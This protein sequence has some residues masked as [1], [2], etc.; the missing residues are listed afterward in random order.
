MCLITFNWNP[1]TICRSLDIYEKIFKVYISFCSSL[2]M[3]SCAR[4]N[5]IISNDVYHTYSVRQTTQK[6]VSSSFYVSIHRNT[7]RMCQRCKTD[8]LFDVSNQ[9]F[10]KLALLLIFISWKSFH[11]FNELQSVTSIDVISC[12]HLLHTEHLY[13]SFSLINS[14]TQ[15]FPKLN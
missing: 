9:F 4:L 13:K 5:S 8:M 12:L 2:K 7:Y 6:D 3:S 11:V 14:S 1:W 15:I 10:S